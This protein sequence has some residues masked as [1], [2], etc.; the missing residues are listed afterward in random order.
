M[1]A[2]KNGASQPRAWRRWADGWFRGGLLG[3]VGG[4][5]DWQVC[6]RSSCGLGGAPDCE[7]NHVQDGAVGADTAHAGEQERGKSTKT[8]AAVGGWVGSG[9]A[10]GSGRRRRR[11]AGLQK[12]QLRAGRSSRL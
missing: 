8:L 3:Q 7:A 10:A 11:L 1:R 6:K 5:G 2:S 12:E 9:R 4:G